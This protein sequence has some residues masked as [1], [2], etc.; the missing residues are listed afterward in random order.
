MRSYGRIFATPLFMLLAACLFLGACSGR[1]SDPY[2]MNKAYRVGGLETGTVS[3][4]TETLITEQAA[5]NLVLGGAGVGGVSGL[6]V[7]GANP[8]GA[9]LGAA[10]GAFAGDYLT[11]EGTVRYKALAITV[12]MDNGAM[13][14]VVQAEDD[15]YLPGDRVRILYERDRAQVQHI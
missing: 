10:A 13:V 3:N 7:T 8:L 12:T 6:L 4:V 9:A 5:D 11:K 15:V 1:A 14:T 2:A